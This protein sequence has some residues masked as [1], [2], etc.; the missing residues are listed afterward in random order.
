MKKVNRNNKEY[1]EIEDLEIEFLL[2]WNFRL[3]ID[4]ALL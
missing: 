4:L 2:H 3:F 1:L